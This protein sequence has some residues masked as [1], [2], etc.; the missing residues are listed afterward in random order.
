MPGGF[1]A[2][3]VKIRPEGIGLEQLGMA[4]VD[5]RQGKGIGLVSSGPLM[6]IPIPGEIDC[7]VHRTSPDYPPP[8]AGSG[9]AI[10]DRITSP[11]ARQSKGEFA[12]FGRIAPP[13]RRMPLLSN[14]GP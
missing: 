9:S 5:I 3:P 11:C 13:I 4:D 1:P 12:A 7:S 2:Q 6:G 8:V 10:I 14:F